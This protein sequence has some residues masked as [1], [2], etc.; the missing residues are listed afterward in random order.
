MNDRMCRQIRIFKLSALISCENRSADK[1]AKRGRHLLCEGYLL[2]KSNK[3]NDLEF[4]LIPDLIGLPP[5][6][7]QVVGTSPRSLSR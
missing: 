7:W 2:A 3:N 5:S 6:L 1:W 4:I